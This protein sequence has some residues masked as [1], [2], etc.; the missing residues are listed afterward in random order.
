[1]NLAL[2]AGGIMSIPPK[3]HGAI[4]IILWNFKLELEQLG[5]TV[6]IFNDQNLPLVARQINQGNFGFVHLH[7]S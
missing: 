7:Y 3:K 5:H 1:M 4:E 2:I 6:V